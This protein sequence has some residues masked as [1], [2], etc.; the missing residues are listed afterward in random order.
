MR[1]P[2]AMMALAV[3]SACGGGGSGGAP[4]RV[5]EAAALDALLVNTSISNPQRLPVSGRAQYNGYMRANLPTG[6]DGARLNYLGDLTMDVNFAA[7]RDEV[8]GQASGFAT[9]SGDTLAGTLAITGGDLYRDTD[10]DVNYTFTGNVDGR[11]TQGGRA[12]VIDAEIEGEFRGR[13]QDGVRGLLFGD[14]VGPAGQDIFDGTFA[15]TRRVE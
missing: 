8:A 7:A 4:D 3:V 15:A 5:A 13:D 1:L 11:L 9:G 14:V 10:P 6:A 12:F 2:F